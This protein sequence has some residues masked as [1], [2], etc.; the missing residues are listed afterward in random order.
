MS[1]KPR[2]AEVNVGNQHVAGVEDQSVVAVDGEPGGVIQT[3]QVIGGNNRLFA[4]VVGL[5]PDWLVQQCFYIGLSIGQK[6]ERVVIHCRTPQ[7][8]LFPANGQCVHS[9]NFLIQ[10]IQT[11][12][13]SQPI[14]EMTG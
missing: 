7:Q 9:G 6:D 2:I 13:D 3:V 5:E 14:N 4:I 1:V 8:V 11:A 12:T 10:I